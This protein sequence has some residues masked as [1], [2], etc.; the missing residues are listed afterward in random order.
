MPAPDAPI[1]R[2]A[3]VDVGTNSTRLLV[4]EVRPDG[5]YRIIDDEKVVTRLGRGTS[6]SHDLDPDAMRETVEAIRNLRAI[7]AGYDVERL[8]AVATCAVR[9]ADNG[10]EFVR[11]VRDDAGVELD[12]IDGDEEARLAYLSVRAAFDIRHGEVAIV[13]IGG[14][15]TELVLT[16]GGI[17]Q[18]VASFPL[19][20]V[21]L[22][23][24]VS[25]DKSPL[26]RL[27][28][29]RRRVRR[30]F[31]A[32][33]KQ[34][35]VA[36]RLMIGTGGTFT[37]LAQM[38][39]HRGRRAESQSPPSV[40]G[41][42]LHLADV[43]RHLELLNGLSVEERLPV[44]GLSPDR[45]EIIVAGLSIVEV[46]MRLLK[47]PRVQV[48]DR[49][50]RDGVLIGMGKELFPDAPGPEHAAPD[51]LTAARQFAERCHYPKQHSEHV[52]TLALRIYDQLAER[53][54]SGGDELPLALRHDGARE[55][56]Q[57]AATLHDV[58]YYINYQRHHVHS[59]HLI[60]HSELPGFSHHELE[61]IANIARYH[62]RAH[63][64]EKHASYRE[65]SETDRSLIRELAAILRVAD[66]LDRTHA[67]TVEDVRVERRPGA[68][69]FTVSARRNPEVDLWGAARKSRL[70]A[71]VFGLEAN[72]FSDYDAAAQEP[73]RAH[74]EPVEPRR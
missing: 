8:R 48:H 45:A 61:L 19:G 13:D 44:P 72:F 20:A 64:K 29:L 69:L 58:G 7:A 56:L 53:L 47:I 57:V 52:A 9:E 6:R 5:S 35:E 14:G 23:E 30:A 71:K 1:R 68:I 67:C 18:H 46:F 63:P 37:T 51:R 70:F 54:G 31:K 34:I 24:A 62:R 59:F 21:R 60:I 42:E 74:D 49:G 40:R 73:S 65:M 66:G 33:M 50:I 55:L 16:S 12:V 39:M 4:A 10:P 32:K 41:C 28:T 15:S 26:K 2:V 38:D 25:N 22:T 11:A 3:T 43:R 17:I 27:Q 36:P